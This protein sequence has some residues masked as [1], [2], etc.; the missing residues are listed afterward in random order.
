MPV[1]LPQGV[2]QLLQY[3]ISFFK[4]SNPV[5]LLTAL[6]RVNLSIPGLQVRNSGLQFDSDFTVTDGKFSRVRSE[7]GVT[8]KLLEQI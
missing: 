5:E 8:L 2:Q 3:C 6:K 4:S 7:Y 1:P